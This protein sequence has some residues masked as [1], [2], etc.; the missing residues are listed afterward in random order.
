[1]YVQVIDEVQERL[2]LERSEGIKF[3]IKL[4]NSTKFD[5]GIWFSGTPEQL[6]NHV[7][8]AINVIKRMGLFNVYT[9]SLT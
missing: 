9:T 2:N 7:R 6:L 3:M 8:Q 1:M 5:T 4:D